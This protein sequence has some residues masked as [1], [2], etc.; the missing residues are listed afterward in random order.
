MMGLLSDPLCSPGIG[1]KIP[2]VG[3]ESLAA[4]AGGGSS[5]PDWTGSLSGGV[6][7]VGGGGAQGVSFSRDSGD[8][9]GGGG[10]DGGD[11]GGD[12][13][14]AADDDPK[15]AAALEKA[16]VLLEDADIMRRMLE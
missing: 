12:A 13:G 5:S 2:L 11:T 4:G 1:R 6:G 3:A 10:G 14:G 7:G 8:G 15:V 9:G 16:L